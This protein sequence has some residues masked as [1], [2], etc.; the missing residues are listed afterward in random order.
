MEII[1]FGEFSFYYEPSEDGSAN[2]P[3]EYL[4]TETWGLAENYV[5]AYDVREDWVVVTAGAWIGMDAI[6]FSK[7]AK[8]V[9]ALEPLEHNY[10]KMLKNIQMSG[11]NNIIPIKAGFW[12]KNEDVVMNKTVASSAD[13]HDINWDANKVL[14][15]CMTTCY[16][17][18]H[19]TEE[20]NVPQS[21]LCIIDIEGA[22]GKFI[23]GM[24]K[25]LPERLLM[26]S[27]HPV[28]PVWEWQDA[29]RG[30]GYAP[31]GHVQE[32]NGMVHSHKFRKV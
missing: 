11:S 1:K 30:K 29:L 32:P 19:F 5:R 6:L 3:A 17:W 10:N 12:N 15:T 4:I 13:G 22:E 8:Q 25:N 2:Q 26:A 27:Y 23:E 20:F 7:K 18:D 14:S 9:F 28:S 16:T 31:D 21:H 24:T